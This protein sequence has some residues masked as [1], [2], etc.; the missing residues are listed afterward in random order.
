M[1]TAVMMLCSLLTLPSFQTD[2]NLDRSKFEK[3]RD[4]HIEAIV[5]Y[6]NEEDGLLIEVNEEIGA[7][8]GF[9][10]YPTKEDKDLRCMK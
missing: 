6:V 4:G 8:M 7:V 3:R 1:K 9:Y 2:L 5:S 10:Y